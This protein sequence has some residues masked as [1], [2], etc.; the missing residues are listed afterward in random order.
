V[1][2]FRGDPARY[3]RLLAD[4]YDRLYPSEDL[5]TEDTIRLL[6]EYA[7][8]RAPRAVLEFGIG[9]GRL[10]LRLRD[11]VLR[12][13]GIDASEAMIARLREQPGGEEICVA[14]GDYADERVS[15]Q[16]S[17]VALLFNN[18]FDPRGEEVQ[19]KCFENA[20]NHLV[21]GGCFVIEAYVL[22]EDQ[23]T[24][25]WFLSPRQRIEGERE[26]ELAI[27][28]YDAGDTRGRAHG[29]GAGRAGEVERTLIHKRADGP[30]V[31]FSVLDTYADTER[32][33]ELAASAG[34]DVAQRYGSWGKEEFTPASRRHVTIYQKRPR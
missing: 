5:E 26:G 6:A 8:R 7:N 32:L 17:L 11:E 19:R 28:R 33:D 29:L 23:L 21:Y 22:R 30:D 27:C 4:T 13:A 25:E 2:D 18:I 31:V 34:F 12:V 3:G 16:F 10:A 1:R 14:L 9:T 15:G 20:A 24:G